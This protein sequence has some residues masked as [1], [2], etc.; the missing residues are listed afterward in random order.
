MGVSEDHS[1]SFIGV[2]VNM[3][4]RHSRLTHLQ[5]EDGDDVFLR[6]DVTRNYVCTIMNRGQSL[7]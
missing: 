2:D 3:I 5:L 7:E 4:I 6:N 1:A